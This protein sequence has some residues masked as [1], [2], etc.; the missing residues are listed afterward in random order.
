MTS[1]KHP[2]AGPKRS[3]QSHIQMALPGIVLILVGIILPVKTYW[4]TVTPLPV[5]QYR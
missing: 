5:P 3:R 2:I 1:K 4:A